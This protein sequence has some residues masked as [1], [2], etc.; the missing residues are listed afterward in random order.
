MLKKHGL[1]IIWSYAPFALTPEFYERFCAFKFTVKYGAE[2]FEIC[3][4]GF[5]YHSIIN[6]QAIHSN[7]ISNKYF[8]A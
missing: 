4:S 6:T 8:H 3:E 5:R 7:K 1:R 2:R